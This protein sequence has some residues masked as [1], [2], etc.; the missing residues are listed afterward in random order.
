MSELNL[1]PDAER[2]EAYLEGTLEQ[3]ERA[4]FESHLV[5]CPRCQGDLEDW[6]ALFF[7]L[8]ALP[9]LE[10]SPDFADRVMERV[11]IMPYSAQAKATSR[12][13]PRTTKGWSVIAAFLALPVVGLTTLVGWLLN[14]PWATSLTA[15]G[16]VTYTVNGL[17]TG[18][19]W[20]T[21]EAESAILANA[22]VQ[23]ALTLAKQ[24]MA[25]AGTG[26]VGLAAAALVLTVGW[27]T[28]V[29]YNNLIRNSTRD[30]QYAPYT[31]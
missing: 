10:P 2:L 18:L 4:L 19:S 14:Q 6:Q 12:W 25:T 5:S 15:Q 16:V 29:L 13:W 8:D 26:G 3:S 21:G 24:Y 20:L 7:A 30:A 31:I 22:L 27:S 17:Q 9:E 1:H 23:S 28:W 11:T